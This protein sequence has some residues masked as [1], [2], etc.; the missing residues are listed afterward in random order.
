MFWSTTTYLILLPL[1]IYVFGILLIS[2]SQT[3]STFTKPYNGKVNGLYPKAMLEVPHT[4]SYAFDRE[5]SVEFMV[6]KE[7]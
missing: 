4:I 6:K 5:F 2:S 7:D 1:V 3:T